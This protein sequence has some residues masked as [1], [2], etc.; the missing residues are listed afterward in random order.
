[1]NGVARIEQSRDIPS[2]VGLNTKMEH[3]I[4]IV[5]IQKANLIRLISFMSFTFFDFQSL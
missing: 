3:T 1:M 4:N 2:P 5:A